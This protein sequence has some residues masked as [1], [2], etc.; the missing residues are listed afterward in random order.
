M[1]HGC[2]DCE[3][4]LSEYEDAIKSHMQLL[5]ATDRALNEHDTARLRK[6]EALL[7]QASERRTK[8]REAVKSHEAMHL[9]EP[10]KST[11]K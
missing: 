4:L 7:V 10:P 11:Q 2:S 1:E 5:A 9:G 6:L 8:A 3:R